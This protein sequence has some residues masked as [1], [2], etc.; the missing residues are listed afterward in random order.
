[1]AV[2]GQKAELTDIPEGKQVNVY[3]IP[4]DENDGGFFARKIDVVLSEEELDKR[5]S[6]EE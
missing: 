5:W 6:T 2:N 4:D 1:V 3:W